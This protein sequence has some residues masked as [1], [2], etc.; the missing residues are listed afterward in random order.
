M[1]LCSKGKKRD[2]FMP[3]HA[4]IWLDKKISETYDELVKNGT[5]KPAQ[6][7]EAP[8]LPTDFKV[9]SKEASNVSAV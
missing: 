8:E 3:N 1:H 4:L 2:V 6:D 9:A 7:I 5:I